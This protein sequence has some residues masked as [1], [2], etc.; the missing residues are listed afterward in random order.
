M[1]EPGLKVLWSQ[2]LHVSSLLPILE[3]RM[4]TNF[5][6]GSLPHDAKQPQLVQTPRIKVVWRN[7]RAGC[8]ICMVPH[9]T[10]K[11]RMRFDVLVSSFQN[12]PPWKQ[13][14]TLPL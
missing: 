6:R 8:Q 1:P 2:P 4:N 3:R 14:L 10:L 11:T 9:E 7:T 13:L 5:F 12:F